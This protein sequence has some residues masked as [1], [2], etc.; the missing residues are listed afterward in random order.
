MLPVLV[1][2]GCGWL[3][4]AEVNGWLLRTTCEGGASTPGA[5]G[6]TQHYVD[7]DGD[8][9][10]GENSL[11]LCAPTREYPVART[12]DC[13][14]ARRDVNPDVS[15]VCD[16]L[17]TDE[18]CDRTTPNGDVPHYRDLDG[19]GF[20]TGSSLS[21]CPGDSADGYTAQ[22]DGDCNDADAAIFPGAQERCDG[23]DNDCD[24]GSV[25]D[26]LVSIVD[27]TTYDGDG[28]LQRAIDEAADAAVLDVCAGTYAPVEI[29]KPI[30][31]RG[32]SRTETMLDAQG[33]G[34]TILVTSTDV[35]LE[36][37]TVR[38]GTGSPVGGT[39]YGGGG[40]FVEAG[41]SLNAVAVSFRDNDVVGY[42]GA[43]YAAGDVTLTNCDV[44]D[45]YATLRGGAIHSEGTAIVA[46]ESRIFYNQ[47]K[48]GA[49]L[50]L[51]GGDADLTGTQVAGNFADAGGGLVVGADAV[52]TGGTISA[53]SANTGGGGIWLRAGTL[54]LVGV[55][56][57]DNVS[58]ANGGGGAW[59]SGAGRLVSENS[60]W[61]NDT[62][63]DCPRANIPSD[64]Y[65]NGDGDLCA[66][67]AADFSCSSLGCDAG[68]EVYTDCICA[69]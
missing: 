8:H 16:A 52:V 58:V 69:R 5:L 7:N 2:A 43:I 56:V 34:T 12:G 29:T 1:L 68:S 4:D 30:T 19:D 62:R 57:S 46:H 11:C 61:V 47:A 21:V 26:G 22:R 67:D 64:L 59:I 36:N 33:T 41:A 48:Y 23:K 24:A 14:D 17:G 25:E 65:T 66:S 54:R 32:V 18:D 15:E 60:N 27:G 37:L 6:C 45:N 3:S 63:T 9:V 39:T 42:G 20:G 44:F 10:G 38:G 53:N 28:N 51:Q 40:A 55:T 35:Y 13:D 31:I 49:G 50:Y